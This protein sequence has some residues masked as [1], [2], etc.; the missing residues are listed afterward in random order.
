M[1]FLFFRSLLPCTVLN[2]RWKGKER[3]AL[4][5][6]GRLGTDH[7][8]HVGQGY[9]RS[10]FTPWNVR[11][12]RS[13]RGDLLVLF[14]TGLEGLFWPACN[15]FLKATWSCSESSLFSPTWG[16][17]STQLEGI[18]GSKSLSRFANALVLAGLVLA[19]FDFTILRSIHPFS[20]RPPHSLFCVRAPGKPDRLGE[21]F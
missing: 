7:P 15:F 6:L 9:C 8:A 12:H 4:R 2:P 20:P 18:P 19:G 17:E 21:S 16:S 14:P 13:F 3:K 10:S 1:F 11:S 5:F